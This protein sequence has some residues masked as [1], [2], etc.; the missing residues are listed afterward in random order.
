MIHDLPKISDGETDEDVLLEWL[1]EVDM[2]F[3]VGKQVHAE[4][5]SSITSLA[6]EQ[7]PIHKLYIPTYPLELF[8]IHR[9][10]V[11]ENNIRGTQ[12]VTMMTGNR[13]DSKVT[14][15]DFSLAVA[16]VSK[17]SE[18]ILEFDGV[19]T[20]FVLLTDSQE[21][22]EGWRNEFTELV[23]GEEALE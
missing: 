1:S 17:A 21:D 20:K 10:S 11:K 4:I 5:I 16:A 3:S 13:K 23:K 19:K 2:V 22:K 7:K 14:G 6:P 15:P 12:N 18:H 9:D 8:N